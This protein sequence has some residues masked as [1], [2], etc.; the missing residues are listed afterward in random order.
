MATKNRKNT[1]LENEPAW[2][3]RRR[4]GAHQEKKAKRWV[5]LALAG[6]VL[7]VALM[8]FMMLRGGPDKI[9]KVKPRSVDGHAKVEKKTIEHDKEGK[10][11]RYIDFSV[12]QS[13][14]RWDAGEKD[15]DALK[16]GQEVLLEYD[17]NMYTEAPVHVR[18][19]HPWVVAKPTGSA[20]SPK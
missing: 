7:V 9:D 19:W 11:H 18:S 14:V 2:K 20:P 5:V 8:L 15:Y 1:V 3:K 4:E 6:G 17:A 16:V 13:K 10:L 12:G